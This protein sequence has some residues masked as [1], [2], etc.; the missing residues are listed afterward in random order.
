[1]TLGTRLAARR[2]FHAVWVESRNKIIDS[3]DLLQDDSKKEQYNTQISCIQILPCPHRKHC[4]FG[5]EN[6]GPHVCSASGL[7]PRCS[8]KWCF[9]SS[10]PGGSCV[11][12]SHSA[13]VSF[14]SRMSTY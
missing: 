13:I 2:I 1:M 10:F 7:L 6:D 11:A 12:L 5:T 8:V 4:Y 9:I 14:H 3:H